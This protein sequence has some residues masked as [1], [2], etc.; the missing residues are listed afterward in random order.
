MTH[1]TSQ[2]NKITIEF[3]LNE[4]LDF[5]QGPY[6]LHHRDDKTTDLFLLDRLQ[7][8]DNTSFVI[9]DIYSFKNL[10]VLPSTNLPHNFIIIL[11]TRK[12]P[13]QD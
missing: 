1:F 7:D 12:Q 10:T 6:P 9:I 3:I 8:L 5:R 2:M 4:G 11:I 13:Q